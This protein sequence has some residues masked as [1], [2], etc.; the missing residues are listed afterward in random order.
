MTKKNRNG[1]EVPRK[2][3]L[4]LIDPDGVY[5]DPM[6]ALHEIIFNEE[7]DKRRSPIYRE[8]G[9]SKIKYDEISRAVYDAPGADPKLRATL[10]EIL[11]P[12]MGKRNR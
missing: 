7:V 5:A 4:T 6:E 11:E 12:Q 9:M 8:W 10:L 1:K 3:I 2:L